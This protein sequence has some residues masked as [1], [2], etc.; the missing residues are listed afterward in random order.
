MSNKLLL[1]KALKHQLEMFRDKL[2]EATLSLR[3]EDVLKV[4]EHMLRAEHPTPPIEP[5][6]VRWFYN[7]TEIHEVIDKP[8]QNGSHR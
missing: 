3:V 6:R 2:R 5:D 1:L 4:Y 7:G 8:G